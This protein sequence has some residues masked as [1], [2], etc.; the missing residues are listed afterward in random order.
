MQKKQT[1]IELKLYWSLSVLQVTPKSFSDFPHSGKKIDFAMK[2]DFAIRIALNR[3][4]FPS[5]KGIFGCL[6]I[7]SLS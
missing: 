3:K 7:Q 6:Q 1:S 2:V 4:L 5:F